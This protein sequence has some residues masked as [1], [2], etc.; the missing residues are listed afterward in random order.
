MDAFI[1]GISSI[2][3]QPSYKNRVL[4]NFQPLNNDIQLDC[5]E[6]VYKEILNPRY[7]RRLGRSIR[8]GLACSN[9]CLADATLDKPDAIIVGTG[10]GCLVDTYKF[11]E[12]IN[13]N[14]EEILNPT[15]FIQ[16][17]HNTVGAQ[18]ALL[19]GCTAYNM[20]FTHN[21]LSFESGVLDAL[22]LLQANEAHQILI[23]GIDET[24]KLHKNLI[25]K[26]E[27]IKG[28]IIGDGASFF[29]VSDQK[30]E[31]S[32]AVLECIEFITASKSDFPD[33]YQAL[34]D[35]EEVSQSN[36]NL[37]LTN[38]QE[39]FS[40]QHVLNYTEYSGSYDTSVAFGLWLASMLLKNNEP[41]LSGINK[42]IS[43]IYLHHATPNNKHAIMILRNV[44]L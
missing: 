41:I 12:V 29:L 31:N 9:E 30:T 24:T 5:I 22:S 13:E 11:L 14:N 27:L 21:E 42:N 10:W 6:P 43:R 19:L 34:I 3:F 33:F 17:T 36:H 2:S 37:I 35:K 4:S 16:S 28:G 25:S 20:T 7:I 1:N 40:S 38:N 32:Y 44:D 23:G 39:F 18:I 8:M 15:P 26:S